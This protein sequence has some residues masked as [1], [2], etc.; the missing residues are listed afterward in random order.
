MWLETQYT[1]GIDVGS[2]SI[3]TV[4]MEFDDNGKNEKLL[5][6]DLAKIG[7]LTK[8]E[9]IIAISTTKRW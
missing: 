1:V 4:L 5:V 6:K 2:N 7:T 8:P 9:A 3:K